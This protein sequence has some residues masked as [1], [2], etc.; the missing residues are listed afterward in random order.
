MNLKLILPII[1]TL[2]ILT[3]TAYAFDSF[4][5]IM[6]GKGTYTQEI[7][8]SVRADP[9]IDTEKMYM[10]IFWDNL[11]VT[12][13]LPSPKYGTSKTLLE[14]RWDKIIT[15]PAN[16]N[17]EGKHQIEI[18][19]EKDTG[20]IKKLYWQYTITE[21]PL[22]TVTAWETFIKENPELIRQITGPQGPIGDNG[23][24]GVKG[25]HGDRG[26]SGE[27]GVKGN[28]GLTGIQGPEGVQGKSGSP[29]Y[30]FVIIICVLCN[31]AT[32]AYMKY[33]ENNPQ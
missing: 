28:I 31:G 13:R 25:V 33:K 5:N 4:Y 27:D 11:P 1:I 26:A 10:R 7:L 16:Y 19:L 29:N 14:H 22:T 15:P 24:R 23:Q 30:L 32:L 8:V 21:G 3:P 12:D 18:W 9:R 20:E 6:P 17:Q 2:S